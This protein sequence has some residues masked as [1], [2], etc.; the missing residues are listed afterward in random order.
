MIMRVYKA[1][2]E[3]TFATRYPGGSSF[4]AFS[5]KSQMKF[6]VTIA[7]FHYFFHF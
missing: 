7:T 1:L 2:T 4:V 6:P 3:F 5:N